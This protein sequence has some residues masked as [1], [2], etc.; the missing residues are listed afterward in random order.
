M[1]EKINDALL[2]FVDFFYAVVFGLIIAK[3]FDNILLP[4]V[5]LADK[6]KSPLL[7]LGVFYL[8]L[9]D[10][11]HGRMLTLRNPY[12]SFRRFF[13]EVIIACCGYGA[14]ARALEGRVAFLFYV[15]L[16]LLLGVL[17]AWLTMK[18]YPASDDRREL[19]L[20]ITLQPLIALFVGGYWISWERLMGPTVGTVLTCVLIELGWFAIL[21][22]ELAIRR[23]LGIQAGPGVPF[24]SF[25]QL[26]RIRAGLLRIQR[27]IRR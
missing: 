20:I 17:W 22:Y 7:V 10:W 4:E 19:V 1:D 2:A 27:W 5:H 21:F 25:Q 26:E 18:E 6:V 12:P 11:L 3:I 15:M 14:A 13:I 16:I 9:W 24:V 8:L 23:K